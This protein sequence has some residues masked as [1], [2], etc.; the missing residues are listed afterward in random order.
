MSAGEPLRQTP[1]FPLYQRYGART[2]PFG[3]WKLPVQFAGIISEHE[4]VRTAAGLFD[5]SHMGE[6]WIEGPQALAAVQHLTINDAAR[7]TPGRIQYSAMANTEGG[8]VDDITVACFAPDRFML[9]VNAANIEKDFRWIRA[10]LEAFSGARAVDRSDATALLALQGPK[11]EE[12][13]RRLTYVDLAGLGYYHFTEGRVAG[14]RSVI[15]RTGYTGEDGFELF[16]EAERGPDLWEELMAVGEALGLRP[17]GLGARDTLR[18]EMGYALYGQDIDDSTNPLEAGLGWITRLDKGEFI[19]REAIWREREVGLKT[20]LA[21][22]VAGERGVPRHEYP[23]LHHGKTVGTVTS[24]TMSPSLK[25]GIGLGYLPREVA[26]AGSEIVIKVRDRD[27]PA[28]V[29]TTPFYRH[30]SARKNV[31]GHK[32]A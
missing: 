24:G 31:S 27:L 13:L 15:S 22:F 28:V 12:I 2:V 29:V 32:E 19:G 23:I 10:H 20:T 25:M 1:L 21:A 5:V 30:G 8:L 6:I 11:A 18:L 9:C 14:I 16:V 26:E 7:L 17:C 3:G 4:A